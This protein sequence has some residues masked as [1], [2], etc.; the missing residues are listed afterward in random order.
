MSRSKSFPERIVLVHQKRV[1]AGDPRRAFDPRDDRRIFADGG[2]GDDPPREA[3]ANEALV[4]ERRLGSIRPIASTTAITAAVPVPPGDRSAP[5]PEKIVT[6]L[7]D[8]RSS[9][10]GAVKIVPA[11]PQRPASTGCTIV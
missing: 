7:S 11:S 10:G 2:P 3:R 8:E 5:A 9:L 6:F 1:L 4:H